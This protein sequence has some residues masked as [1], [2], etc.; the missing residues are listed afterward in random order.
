M[1]AVYACMDMGVLRTR[2]FKPS[3]VIHKNF[4]LFFSKFVVNFSQSCSFCHSDTVEIG[5][6][7]CSQVHVKF[8]VR[9]AVCVRLRTGAHAQW[10][11]WDSSAKDVSVIKTSS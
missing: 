2:I 7:V 4:T 6:Y 9:M 1:F 3:L 5:G 11:T 10:D 8:P